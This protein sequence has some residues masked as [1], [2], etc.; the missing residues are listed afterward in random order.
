[1]EQVHSSRGILSRIYKRDPVE[2]VEEVSLTASRAAS[3]PDW[4]DML[5]AMERRRGCLGLECRK[6]PEGYCLCSRWSSWRD[7]TDWTGATIYMVVAAGLDSRRV[8]VR[9]LETET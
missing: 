4:E 9:A 7:F 2:I 1:M 6:T 3:E 5:R 8:A